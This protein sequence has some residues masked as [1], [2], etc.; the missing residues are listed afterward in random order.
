MNYEPLDK[1]DYKERKCLIIDPNTGMGRM[2]Q[3]DLARVTGKL[4]E[5]LAVQD[6]A[7]AERHLLYWLSE[8]KSIRD[9][10]GEFS[11]RNEMMGYYRKQG[12][13][14]KALES[15]SEALKLIDELGIDGTLSAGTCYINTGTVYDSF[16]M[17]DK[18]YYWFEKALSIYKDNGNADLYKLGGLF[19]N[20]ALSLMDM[21]RYSEAREMYIQAI[22][23]MKRVENGE[24]EQAI[25]YLNMAD[26]AA[27]EKGL[28]NAQQEIDGYLERAYSLIKSE[29][30]PRN[31]YYAFVCEKCAP[32][33]YCYG[34]D[35]EGEEIETLSETIYKEIKDE[36]A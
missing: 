24:L 18:A 17:P 25:T 34:H 12:M 36:R 31:G 26:A 32:G 30:L 16:G 33:F 7:G 9:K 19:N 21:Q 22:D 2:Q 14:D 23:T 27:L 8:A 4:D 11:I 35:K 29:N 5:Y 28:D 13:K 3:V 15:A 1:E 20:M 10:R 6:F